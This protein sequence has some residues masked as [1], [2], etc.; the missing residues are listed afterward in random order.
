MRVPNE[1]GFHDLHNISQDIG[2]ICFLPSTIF[3]CLLCLHPL[4]PSIPYLPTS[5]R[6][7]SVAIGS[8]DKENP[9]AIR[10]HVVVMGLFWVKMKA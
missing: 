5:F 10:K 9:H 1:R 4:H 2:E 7:G 6:T 3:S 8:C